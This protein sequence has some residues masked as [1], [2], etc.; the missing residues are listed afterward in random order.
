M[1]ILDTL[2]EQQRITAFSF[3]DQV[4]IADAK[5]VLFWPSQ[6]TLVVSDLH[7]EKGTFYHRFAYPLPGYDS[8]QTLNS[9][10]ELI[11]LY[12]PHRVICLG[13]SFHDRQGANR[14]ADDLAERLISWAQEIEWIWILGNHDPDVPEWLGGQAI[15]S[16][17]SGGIEFCHEPSPNADAQVFGH[18]HPKHRLQLAH[19]RVTDKCFIYTSDKV[20][21]PSFGA[22]T[23]GLDSQDDVIKGLWQGD[24]VPHTLLC[25]QQKIWRIK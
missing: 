13:D 12:R 8:A 10:G 17:S 1:S 16:W 21:M 22:Y 5:G 7:L 11:T 14:L 9:L 24:D 15:A 19:R 23:G 2:R 18:F 20:L 25:H 4:F 6:S 3:R